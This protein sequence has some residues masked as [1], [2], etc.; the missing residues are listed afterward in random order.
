MTINARETLPE[1]IVSVQY[2][3]SQSRG[4]GSENE[5]GNT[6]RKKLLRLR[7]NWIRTPKTKAIKKQTL[8]QVED[9]KR[10]AAT[11][12]PQRNNISSAMNRYR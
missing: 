9:R 10:D 11:A 4:A 3:N 1:A 2:K 7:G 5:K 8:V 12:Q 6:F